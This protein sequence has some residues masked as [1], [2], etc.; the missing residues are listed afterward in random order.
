MQMAGSSVDS[1]TAITRGTDLAGDIKM[2]GEMVDSTYC[3]RG[4]DIEELT[5]LQLL[6]RGG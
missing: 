3:T 1:T 5:R 4:R 6:T 2:A